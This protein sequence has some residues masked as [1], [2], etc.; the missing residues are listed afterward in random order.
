MKIKAYAII[1]KERQ[2]GQHSDFFH[3]DPTTKFAYMPSEANYETTDY[4][5][6][7]TLDE[8][9]EKAD[10][11]TS[12]TAREIEVKE[13]EIIIKEGVTNET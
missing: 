6:S 2:E 7:K 3:S 13:V 10:F 11:I 5:L 1:D 12:N 4:I 8:A 9:K